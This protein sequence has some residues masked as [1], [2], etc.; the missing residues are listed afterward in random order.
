MNIVS[1]QLQKL[2]EKKN[3]NRLCKHK[4]SFFDIYIFLNG[5]KNEKCCV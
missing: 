2:F 3:T 4:V 5:K 1:E